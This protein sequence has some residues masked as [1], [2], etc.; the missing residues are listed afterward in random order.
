[1]DELYYIQNGYVGN[2]ILWWGINGAGYTCDITKA[3]KYTRKETDQI[4]QRPEDRAWPCEY[5][6]NN[7]DAHKMVIDSQYLANGYCLNG[8]LK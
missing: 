5:I 3:G 1:M 8:K 6:D 4:I 2:A 7:A